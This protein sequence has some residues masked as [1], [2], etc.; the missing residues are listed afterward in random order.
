MTEV[1]LKR[2]MTVEQALRKLR[3]ILDRE[4]VFEELR[5]RRYYQPPSVKR[6]K[7]QKIAKWAT[8]KQAE[9]D[10]LWNS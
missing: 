3:K 5:E 2:N 6:R 1:K 10:S 8:K 4:G 9:E 7:A